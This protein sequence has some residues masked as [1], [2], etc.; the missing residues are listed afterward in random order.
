[1]E[2]DAR[3]G[4]AS[5]SQVAELLG[6][7]EDDVLAEAT[8]LVGDGAASRGWLRADAVTALIADVTPLLSLSDAEPLILKAFRQAQESLKTEWTAMAVPVL[9]NR[10]LQ[11]SSKSFRESDYGS[12]NIWHFVTQFPKVIATEGVRPR[13]RVRLIEPENVEANE[14]E[15]PAALDPA[16]MGR[17]RQD[18]WRALFDYS[19]QETFVWDEAKGRAR[20]R[21][22]LDPE[23]APVLPTLSAEDMNELRAEFVRLQEK[24]SDHDAVRLD[25]WVTRGGPTVAL[26]RLYRGLWNA[27]LK[28]HAAN[29]LRAFFLSEGLDVPKDLVE[30]VS[31]HVEPER[32]VERLRRLAH[33]YIDAMTA[34]ELARLSIEMAVVLRI[35]G[36][37]ER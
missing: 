35:P 8:R 26:P 15:T 13:E 36:H 20:V 5:L 10:L 7:S 29:T 14:R 28:S 23:S 11:L 4:S 19:A 6:Q 21:S 25:E 3:F 31:T 37:A 9:K 16:G 12:P 24:V 1:M 2:E 17:I 32:E 33:R 18:L 22:E 30:R 27:H 34:E